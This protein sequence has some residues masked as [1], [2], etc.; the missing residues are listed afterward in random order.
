MP[1]PSVL[2]VYKDYFPPVQGGMEK[3]IHW[4]CDETRHDYHV[5]VL[6][7]SS[8]RRTVDEV[9]DGVRVV[10]IG[11][12]G[13]VLSTPI[14]P[15]FV[16]WLR[17]LDS[18]ILHFHM[19]MPMGELAY[20]LARPKH[21]RVVATYQSDIVRQRLTGA[22]FG[23]IQRRFLDRADTIMVG[24][25]RYL[26]SSE[27]LRPHRA[28]CRVVPLGIPIDAYDATPASRAFGET[29]V[30]RSAGRAR[31]VF[32]GLLR[33]YKGLTYLIEAMKDLRDRACLFIGGDAPR[34][35]AEKRAVLERQAREA[36]LEDSV[37][38]LGAISHDEAVGL[39]RAGDVFCLPSH[40]RAE[41]FG[42]AQVE[43]MACG[44]PVVSCNLD[45]G[46]PEINRDGETGLVVEPANAEAL[47]EA[48]SRLIDDPALRTQMGE[49][50]RRRAVES[51]SSKVMGQNVRAVYEDVL[52]R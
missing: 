8:S 1:K 22:L 52:A 4:M 23:P 51:Y 32:L 7:A 42:L 49:A 3:C 27:T 31:I 38:F 40:L 44:L 35:R 37:I 18:D 10:R 28:R 25:Q 24:S 2:H 6:V 30:A 50:G 29:V 11:C 9:I 16:G 12:W 26:D 33:Y 5:R 20:L 46:V 43:A 34:N 45:T 17:R 21:G 41:A 15:G 13:R 48:L 47:R 19:P 39:L 14:A 36:G